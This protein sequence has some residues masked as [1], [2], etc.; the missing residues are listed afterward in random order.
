MPTPYEYVVHWI[1]IQNQKI[2]ST[3]DPKYKQ[4]LWREKH[5]V[6]INL[7][8]YIKHRLDKGDSFHFCVDCG[9]IEFAKYY[10]PVK[11]KLCFTCNFWKEREQEYLNCIN[12]I[13][14]IDGVWY[15]DGGNK[16][17]SNPS[18]LGHAGREFTIKMLHSDIKW[19]TNNL[20][21]GGD[22]PKKYRE[23]T[24]KDNAEFI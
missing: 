11:S 6:E 3:D 10:E 7:K 17:N 21:C 12:D 4:E 20:W 9:K 13:L 18:Y 1:E 8:H 15:S 16:P 14:I 23:T 5:V 19:N 24:L 22:I 2:E